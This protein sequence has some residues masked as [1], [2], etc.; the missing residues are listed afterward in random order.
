MK[1]ENSRLRAMSFTARLVRSIDRHYT[2]SFGLS[3]A[4]EQP[5]VRARR[6]F[7]IKRTSRLLARNAEGKT[8]QRIL[9]FDDHPDSLRLAFGRGANLPVG[10]TAPQSARWWDL[11]LAWMLIIGALILMFSPLLLK[12]PS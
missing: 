2:N 9:I 11:M 3:S 7:V 8:I 6:I 10:R 4:N 1:K 12:F 5:G